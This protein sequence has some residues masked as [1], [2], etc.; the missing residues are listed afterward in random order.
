MIDL[1]K[2]LDGALG[3]VGMKLGYRSLS[4]FIHFLKT[5]LGNVLHIFTETFY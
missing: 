1:P 5:T 3:T 2:N 4:L